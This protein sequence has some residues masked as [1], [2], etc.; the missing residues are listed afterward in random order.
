MFLKLQPALAPALCVGLS[1]FGN[2]AHDKHFEVNNLN[3]MRRH[4]ENISRSIKLKCSQ[5]RY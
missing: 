4:P 2:P 1:R 5:Y 3:Q